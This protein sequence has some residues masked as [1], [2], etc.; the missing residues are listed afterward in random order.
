MKSLEEAAKKDNVL[1]SV[2]SGIK[3]NSNYYMYS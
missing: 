2:Y 1:V 3:E